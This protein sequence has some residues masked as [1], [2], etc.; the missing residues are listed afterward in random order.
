MTE[1]AELFPGI[2]LGSAARNGECVAPIGRTRLRRP[3]PA[4]RPYRPPSPT[5]MMLA[6]LPKQITDSFVDIGVIL[7]RLETDITSIASS[8]A[9]LA[10]NVDQLR[11]RITVTAIE[12]H[13]G[14]RPAPEI[15]PHTR[16]R[17]VA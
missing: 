7:Q 15:P 11:V 4:A 8:A 16:R 14:I 10:E 12:R 3:A 9:D 17:P 13:A 5:M 6:N 2:D 1:L